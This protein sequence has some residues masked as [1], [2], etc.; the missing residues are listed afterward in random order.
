[1]KKVRNFGIILFIMG[2][3]LLLSFVPNITGFV[4]LENLSFLWWKI[5]GPIFILAGIFLMGLEKRVKNQKLVDMLVSGENEGIFNFPAMGEN[6][7]KKMSDVFG[8]DMGE[9]KKQVNELLNLTTY[10][11][12]DTIVD[13][14]CGTGISTQE[15]LKRKPKKIIG[16]DLSR[17]MLK[18]AKKKLKNNKDIELKVA[19]AE[20]LSDVVSNA[21]KI[22]SVNTFKYFS[23]PDKVLDEI[24]NSLQPNGEYLF[25]IQLKT[26]KGQSVYN[27]ISRVIEKVMGKESGKKVELLELKGLEPKYTKKDIERM[28]K[29]SHLKIKKYE[30][31][32]IIYDPKTLHNMYEQILTS[33][34]PGVAD[35]L[36]KKKAQK[37]FQSVRRELNKLHKS[38]KFSAG[39]TAYISLKKS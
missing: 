31:Q 19:S 11:P 32:P 10:T 24:Y 25:N 20:E 33:F 18:Q 29:R 16:V 7:D 23:N 3:I 8:R 1:M 21:D 39:T 14:G 5:L 15:I 36:G 6:Y 4:I 13:L 37:V 17:S 12:K 38:K 30:E 27:Q 22:V 35:T 9:Y 34:E 2:M 26:S 28:V